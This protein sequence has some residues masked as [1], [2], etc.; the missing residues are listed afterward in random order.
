MTQNSKKRIG[1]QGPPP[2][3]TV[4]GPYRVEH[5]HGNALAFAVAVSIGT[6]N[7]HHVLH[8]WILR[9]GKTSAIQELAQETLPH[10]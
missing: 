6:Y 8:E 4:D 2:D 5:A 10:N 7:T 9:S 1:L 3:L